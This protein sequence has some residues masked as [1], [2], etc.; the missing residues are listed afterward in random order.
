MEL[1][2]KRNLANYDPPYFKVIF[3]ECE[4]MTTSFVYP[5][6]CDKTIPFLNRRIPLTYKIYN[7]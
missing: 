3:L 6:C 4:R 1:V 5:P 2:M 7:D